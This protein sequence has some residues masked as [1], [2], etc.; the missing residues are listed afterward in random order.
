MKVAFNLILTGKAI[1]T[2]FIGLNSLEQFSIV[3]IHTIPT[4]N[5]HGFIYIWLKS[6]NYKKNVK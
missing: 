2:Q 4:T 5:A 3:Y 1:M 6:L